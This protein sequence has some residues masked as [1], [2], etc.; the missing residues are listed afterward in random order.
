M[1][2]RYNINTAPSDDSDKNIGNGSATPCHGSNEFVIY[3]DDN[4]VSEKCSSLEL[5]QNRYRQIHEP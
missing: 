5:K 4:D 2:G 3:D 1:A